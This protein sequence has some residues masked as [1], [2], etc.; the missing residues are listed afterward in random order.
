MDF[1]VGKKLDFGITAFSEQEIIDFAR[2]FDP[3][4]F[5]VDKE[6]AKKTMFG[7]IIASGPHLFNHVYQKEWIPRYG[8]TVICGLGV[9]NWK[10]IKPVCPDQKIRTEVTILSIKPNPMLGGT[11]VMWLFEFKNEKGEMIQIL[12]TE[13]MHKIP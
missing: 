3:L 5:H 10:F 11:A 4:D 2:A 12:Q 6:A 9:Y 1:T 13:V 8:K 7:G